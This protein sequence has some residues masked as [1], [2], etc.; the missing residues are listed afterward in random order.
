MAAAEE[1]AR[2]FIH[3]A[4]PTDDEEADYLSHLRLQKLLYY[5][6][7]WHLAAVG[8]RLFGERI[9]AWQ[10]GPVVPTVYAVFKMFER[11]IPASEGNVPA[12]MTERTKRFVESVWDM[13][14]NHSATI[15][16]AKTHRESPW[17]EARKGLPENARSEEEI[18]PVSMKAYFHP[19]YVDLL[20]KKDPRIKPMAW[21][22]TAEAVAAGRVR[23]PEVIL[24]ELQDRRAGAGGA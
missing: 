10:H 23:S 17:V 15:L 3:L 20:K 21:S 13:Y 12:S 4:T 11:A 24:R 9:E 7:S 5:A 2:Y 1:I 19:N 14:K 6:Q 22:A 18:T 8:T 16:R